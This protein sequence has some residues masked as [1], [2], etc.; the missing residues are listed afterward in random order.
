MS[1]DRFKRDVTIIIE[2]LLKYP[3]SLQAC[4]AQLLRRPVLEGTGNG[5]SW[6]AVHLAVPPLTKESALT[7]SRYAMQHNGNGGLKLLYWIYLTPPVPYAS[8]PLR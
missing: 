7:S 5:L 1:C 3:R 2:K 6:V 8:S 4:S